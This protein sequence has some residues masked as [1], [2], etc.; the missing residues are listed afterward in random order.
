MLFEMVWPNFKLILMTVGVLDRFI[1]KFIVKPV[2]LDRD[3]HFDCKPRV[4]YQTVCCG[5]GM[6]YVGFVLV[7]ESN[8]VLGAI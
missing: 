8:L 6:E 1:V 3:D 5:I 7:W 4:Y 2:I